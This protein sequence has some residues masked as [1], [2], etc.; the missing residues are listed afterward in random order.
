MQF[1]PAAEYADAKLVFDIAGGTFVAKGRQ[2]IKPGW[3]QLLGKTEEDDTDADKVPPLPLGE[4]LL[5]REGEIKQRKTEPPRA[6]TEASLL[7]AMTGI[8][9]YV[10]D[11]GLKKILRETD[12]LGT[13]AT[14]AGILDT[15]FKRQLLSR[16]GKAIHSTPAGR[17]LIH[18]LPKASTYPDM[19][20]NWE[21]QLQ[22]MAEKN[23]AYSPF[24][25][26]L[27]QSVHVMINEVKQGEVPESLRH[28][29]KVERPAY[30]KKRRYSAK[31]KTT[32]KRKPASPR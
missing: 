3:K 29:P 12:G 28:L 32:S 10:E 22:G 8:S 13:E 27:T 1:Y 9:R 6:F 7:Q 14:R 4:K 26:A 17:G 5:C 25:E 24:M 11:K 15:L 2:L 20:A 23:Q 31:G 21:H 18:S 30:R 16:Q 19:T